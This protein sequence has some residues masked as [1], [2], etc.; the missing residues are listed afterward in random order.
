[1]KNSLLALLVCL[2]ASSPC[3]AWT[4][5]I[6]NGDL[7]YEGKILGN[8][9]IYTSTKDRKILG[10]S[11][12]LGNEIVY[13]DGNGQHVGSLNSFG[14]NE[15][16]FKDK[17]GAVIGSA[18]LFGK[19]LTYKD[20]RGRH[21]GKAVV[22]GG[23]TLY[24][25]GRNRDIGSADTDTMPLR[26]VPLEEYLLDMASPGVCLTKITGV[27]WSKGAA[28]AGVRA[29]D[30][31]IGYENAGKTVFD[32]LQDDCQKMHQQVKELVKNGNDTEDAVMIV[33]RPA[34]NDNGQAK[35]KIYKTGKLPSGLKGFNYTTE[36]SGPSFVR[37][38]S[39]D[40]AGQIK[41]L[42]GAGNF[43][44]AP[45]N[46]P[47][48]DSQKKDDADLPGVHQDFREEIV[49]GRAKTGW[50]WVRDSDGRVL[51]A[52]EVRSLKNKASRNS[53]RT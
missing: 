10:T 48:A 20:A 39:A 17:K 29:G 22:V 12:K 38:S 47:P 32:Y 50:F 40:Y 52:A 6:K 43:T 41:K 9:M 11:R 34:S 49:G 24:K 18:V 30:I 27:S 51:S 19:E 8:E 23:R 2:F 46:I 28:L 21:V 36:D 42:Y 7:A 44:E 45:V 33:Y 15:W 3:W 53:G 37:R 1:M 35:G 13:K 31:L 25:D 14:N 26:P 5:K 4:I 16:N